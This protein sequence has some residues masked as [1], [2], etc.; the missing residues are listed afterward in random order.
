MTSLLF[1]YTDWQ[2]NTVKMLE[3]ELGKQDERLI[4]LGRR[5]TPV[6]SATIRGIPYKNPFRRLSSFEAD[7]PLPLLDDP[8]GFEAAHLSAYVYQMSRYSRGYA[9]RSH[10]LDRFHEYRDHFHLTARKLKRMIEREA[11]TSLLFFNMPHTG[12][13]YLLYRLAESMGLRVCIFMVS[14]FENRFFS[15]KSIEGFGRLNPACSADPDPD[16]AFDM[17]DNQVKA[18]VQ[19]YMWG[20]YRHEKAR[21]REMAFAVL[22]LLRRS[23]RSFAEPAKLRSEIAEVIRLQRSLKS[24]SR[25]RREIN[26]GDKTRKFLRW[27]GGLE[28]DPSKLPERFVYVPMHFQPEM[29]T[30]PQGG[31]FGDQA[32]AIEMLSACLPDGMSLV[33]K[34]NPMQGGYHRE[35]TFTDR[36]RQLDKVTVAHPTMD[37][38]ALEAKCEAVATITGTAGWEAIR[39]ERPCI[40]FGHA[41]YRSCPGVHQFKAGMDIDAVINNPPQRA[42]SEAFLRQAIANSH[43]GII[44]EFFLKDDS[45]AFQAQNFEMLTQILKGLLMGELESSFA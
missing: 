32:L 21:L 33:A 12:D 15:T 31:V 23:P 16:V 27:L 41:W 25:T 42:T 44:Y 18:S 4:W 38:R 29:T 39:D 36:L 28:T 9:S 30:A 24:R 17:L 8:I 6:D 1:T 34:E 5:S 22:T 43:E 7:G 37:S 40:C 10:T 11:I 14:P 13:D 26:Y 19:S 2:A 35:Q 3:G 20:T 45:P